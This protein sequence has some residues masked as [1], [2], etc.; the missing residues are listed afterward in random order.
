[1]QRIVLSTDDVPE[2]QRF[3]YW[4]EAIGEGLVGVTFE[5]EAGQE[6][7][8]NARIDASV[9]ESLARMRFR[10]DSCPV[11]R[12]PRDIARRG[13][14]DYIFLAREASDSVRYNFDGR[15]FANRRGNIFVADPTVPVA[16][17][18]RTSYDHESW[19]FPRKLL[20]P[21]LKRSQL[22]RFLPLARGDGLT[23]M[24]AAYLDAFAAQLD[25][26]DDRDTHFVA[27]NFCRLL[28]VACGA[29]MGEHEEAI[30][31][32]R[33]EE[34]K[35]YVTLHLSDPGLTPEKAAAALKIS[36]RHLHRMFEPSGMSFAQFIARGRLEEC[37]A[38]L[39]MPD[40]ER[41][42]ADVAFAWGFNSMPTFYRAFRQAFGA[43]PGE[44][45]GQIQ[46]AE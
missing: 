28:A 5:R 2:A 18:T 9:G 44:L 14:D 33:L 32:A 6:R 43:A 34:A 3:S 46:S 30:R 20:A 41:T 15:E 13:W 38:A 37:R 29:A 23:G 31:L 21:H 1:M 25:T 24:I 26:L 40:G 27:D 22:P 16:T 45:R 4:R 7:A 36:V 11:F 35:R 17:E 12:R 10:V 19:L 8:F 39:M 42:V